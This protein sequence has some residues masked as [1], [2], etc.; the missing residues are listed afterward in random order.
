VKNKNGKSIILTESNSLWRRVVFRSILFL[1]SGI[2]FGRRSR[3]TTLT[4]IL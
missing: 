4:Y 3:V 2:Y 1:Q